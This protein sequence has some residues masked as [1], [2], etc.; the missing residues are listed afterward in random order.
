[1]ESG[2]GE[3]SDTRRNTQDKQAMHSPGGG[4]VKKGGEVF[5][6]HSM[7]SSCIIEITAGSQTCA[8]RG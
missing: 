8:Q 5:R 1:M 4:A 2:W 7:P 6:F 3:K